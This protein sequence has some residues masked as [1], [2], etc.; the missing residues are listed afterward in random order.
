MSTSTKLRLCLVMQRRRLDD[1]V[2]VLEALQVCSVLVTAEYPFAVESVLSYG[3][4]MWCQS[5]QHR[6]QLHPVV[7]A[8]K[9]NAQFEGCTSI[10]AFSS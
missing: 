2:D 10:N 1:V 7:S 5:Q 4:H 3:G 9:Q 8:H 6:R